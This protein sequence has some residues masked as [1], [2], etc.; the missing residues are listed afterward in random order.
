M[1]CDR[2]NYWMCMIDRMTVQGDMR[3]L[4]WGTESGHKS[5]DFALRTREDV[6]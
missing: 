6:P 2:Q 4:I 5:V 3:A 1:V